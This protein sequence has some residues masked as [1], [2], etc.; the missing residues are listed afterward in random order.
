MGLFERENWGKQ[1]RAATTTK[2]GNKHSPPHTHTTQT[3]LAHNT[4]SPVIVDM[5]GA[6][7]HHLAKPKSQSLMRGGSWSSNKV[8]SILRSLLMISW[9]F[10]GFFC[11]VFLCCGGFGGFSLERERAKW[12]G[13][14]PTNT[15]EN[16]TQQTN[17]RHTTKTT[18]NCYAPVR[19][20]VLVAVLHGA[21]DLLEEVARL[22]LLHHQA[23][24]AVERAKLQQDGLE[25]VVGHVAAGDILHHQAEVRAVCFVL[26]FCFFWFCGVVLCVCV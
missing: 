20:A 2:R 25:D 14:R 7:V 3:Q 9:L 18:Q 12:E 26:F 4:P 5:C 16:N 6:S 22:V 13:G 11:W 21:D 23:V 1:H 10:G 8:L 15:Q 17:K 19:D 24:A